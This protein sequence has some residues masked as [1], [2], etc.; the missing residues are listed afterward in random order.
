[1]YF[2]SAAGASEKN[3]PFCFLKIYKLMTRMYVN[4]SAEYAEKDTIE[5][6]VTHPS[7]RLGDTPV[8]S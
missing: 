3:W 6:I 7:F 1:M 8:A 2:A 5:T 4:V